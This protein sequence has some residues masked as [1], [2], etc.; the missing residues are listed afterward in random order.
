MFFF[1]NDGINFN[2]SGIEHAQV[3]RL[4]LFKHHEVPAR[5]VTRQF[6]LNLHEIT[7]DAG[8][9]DDDFVNLFDFFQGT[10]TYE[11]RNFTIEDLQLPDGYEYEPEGVEKLHV[12]EKG[13][14][15][16]II[17]KR[18]ADDERLNWVQYFGSNG[19]L[20]RM[21]WYDTR[22]FAALEQFF[23]FG[24]KL[25]SEQ[26]L[27]P[28]GMAVYQRYRMTS[29]QGEEE[30]TLQRLLNYHGHD[31]E[32][33]DF[34]ALTSFFLDQINLSTHT[35]NTIIVDRTFELAYA[36]QSMDTAIYKVMHL[37]NNH[38]NDDD[39]ILTSDLNFNYQYM[40]GNR[41]RWNG[42]IALTPWQRDEFVARYGA[43]DPTVYE[44]PGAVTD[45]KILEKPHVPWQ[46]RKKN[47]VIMVARL[48]P[49]KQQDVLIRAWQQVQKAFPDATLNFW[50][51]SNGDTGQQLKELVKDL[52]LGDSV[53]FNDYTNDISQVY[54]QAQLLILPS[55]AEGL[56]LTLVEAQAHGLPIIAS[57]V[58]YG[59]R[60]IVNDGKDGFLVE[61]GNVNQLAD[62]IMALLADP[63][64]LMKFSEQAYQDS[65]KYSEKAVWKKWLPLVEDAKKVA[66]IP[67]SVGAI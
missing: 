60:D 33:A 50:G 27:A 23:S 6:A 8:I 10:M 55:R 63:T 19:R 66:E 48:A 61:N 28:S 65:W 44:I 9:N 34:E 53:R 31:Y 43:T 40:I 46:D 3:K 12:K 11:A 39:D 15:I 58:R 20:V 4:R 51:Y 24:T 42:I 54:E 64:E 49:E 67:E 36:V 7:R 47:S 59:A 17:A 21:V 57:D 30:T 26:I 2:K 37:H 1:L 13:K 62:R 16:M 25:V 29:P 45:Q 18:G 56:P 52:R 35:A 14:Q 32:F 41:K 5:I 22:G 38:L